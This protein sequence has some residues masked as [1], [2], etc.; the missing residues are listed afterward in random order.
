MGI[1]LVILYVVLASAGAF[2][3]NK[4]VDLYKHNS[5]LDADVKTQCFKYAKEIR[6]CRNEGE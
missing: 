2:G 4:A 6:E 5:T 1:E 3:V